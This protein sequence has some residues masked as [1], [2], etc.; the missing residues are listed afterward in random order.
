LPYVASKYMAGM[1]F[2]GMA[3]ENPSLRINTLWPKTTID[4]PDI[5]NI[6]TGSYE[7]MSKHHRKPQ[8]MADACLA[9]IESQAFGQTGENFIDEEVL[10]SVNVSAF[11]D[12]ELNTQEESKETKAAFAFDDEEEDPFNK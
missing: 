9:L 1:F 7:D 5:C 6:I 3:S 4:A 12:Y 11:D 8:I 2:S 10:R